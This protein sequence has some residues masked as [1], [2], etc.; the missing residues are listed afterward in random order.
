MVTS[1]PSTLKS[2]A[3]G[4]QHL[5][6]G[7]ARVEGRAVVRDRRRSAGDRRARRGRGAGPASIATTSRLPVARG[8]P[9]RSRLLRRRHPR[10]PPSPATPRPRAAHAV[11]VHEAPE[12][13]RGEPRAQRAQ[14]RT[15]AGPAAASTTPPCARR[16]RAAR[17]RHVHE[18]PLLVDPA[19]LELTHAGA[20]HGQLAGGG[21]VRREARAG[22][23]SRSRFR[24][25]QRPAGCWPC[26]PLRRLRRCCRRRPPPRAGS[27]ST[28]SPG[29]APRCRS[30]RPRR[31]TPPGSA[32]HRSG[33]LDPDR[34]F[35]TSATIV[36][37]RAGSP[38]S[39]L[40]PP[41]VPC[42]SP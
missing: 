41:L 10:R 3:V 36:V 14:R 40:T 24:R 25:A 27:G 18:R 9:P 15:P 26:P 29:R 8:R 6:R 34:S 11:A 2:S 12:R 23:R 13:L 19:E 17:A 28:R 7:A 33:S 5:G 22:R 30:A 42:S 38:A 1:S 20:A 35:A 31:R 32:A 4:H 37:A 21:Q 39:S 16:E